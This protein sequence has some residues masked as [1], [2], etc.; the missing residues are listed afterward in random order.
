[1][2]PWSSNANK[3][4]RPKE[5]HI[6]NWCNTGRSVLPDMYI[7]CPRVSA[8]ISSNARV[9]VLQLVCYT[10]GMLK[11]CQN[12]DTT[13]Q[14]LHIVWVVNLIVSFSYDVCVM[15]LPR[16][17]SKIITETSYP[18]L[19]IKCHKLQCK[20]NPLGSAVGSAEQ[21]WSHNRNIVDK[22]YLQNLYPW[23]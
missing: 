1:M 13:A 17:L 9:P 4:R 14:L 8:D 16:I 5:V 10:S 15:I 19:T 23:L 21:L 12:L 20:N 2:A 7:W 11:I 3:L 18:K 22:T 6:C